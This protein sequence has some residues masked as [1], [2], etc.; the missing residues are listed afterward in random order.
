MMNEFSIDVLTG[1]PDENPMH[2]PAITAAGAFNATA[3]PLPLP[4]ALFCS[5]LALLGLVGHRRTSLTR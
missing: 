3:V 4:A 1:A 2:Y 5:G